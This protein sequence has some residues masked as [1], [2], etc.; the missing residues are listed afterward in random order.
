ME[1]GI[2]V[3]MVIKW[4]GKRTGSRIGARTGVKTG[5]RTVVRIGVRTVVRIGART[6]V[7]TGAMIGGMTGV[8]VKTEKERTIV[9]CELKK[10]KERKAG[11][12][13]KG[14]NTKQ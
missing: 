9:C 2:V 8:S 6:G 11:G 1:V 10:R 7:R 12:E 3:V 13:R 5:V 4:T 14:K